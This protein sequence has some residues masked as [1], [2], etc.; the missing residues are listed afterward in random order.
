MENLQVPLKVYS[1]RKQLALETPYVSIIQPKN[2]INTIDPNVQTID[3]DF[4][5]LN[6]LDLSINLRKEKR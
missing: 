3:N 4:L 2:D 5:S 1:R 6:N